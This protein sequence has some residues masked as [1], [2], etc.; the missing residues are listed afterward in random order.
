MDVHP[1]IAL[2]SVILGAALLGPVGALIGIPLTAAVLAIVDTYSHRH[3]LVP[4]LEA[5]D[6]RPAPE[7][8]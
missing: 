6:P 3:Q 8:E 1:A 2:A 5:L 7:R 4:E